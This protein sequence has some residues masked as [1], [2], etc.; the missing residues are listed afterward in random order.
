MKNIDI[1]ITYPHQKLYS[2]QLCSLD[3]SSHFQIVQIS[4]CLFQK[5]VLLSCYV[6][7]TQITMSERK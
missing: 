5:Q 7:Y 6:F 3:I 4:I 1:F 2:I